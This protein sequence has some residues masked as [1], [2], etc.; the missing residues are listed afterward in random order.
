M[1]NFPSCLAESVIDWENKASTHC[2]QLENILNHKIHDEQ[3]FRIESINCHS[4]RALKD[5]AGCV[6]RVGRRWQT[7]LSPLVSLYLLEKGYA[8]RLSGQ[9]GGRLGAGWAGHLG[10]ALRELMWPRQEC[11][12]DKAG[13]NVQESAVL[14]RPRGAS[15]VLS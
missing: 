14:R 4:P 2:C 10:T 1:S 11:R 8:C 7:L 15:S 13:V 12:A 3:D 9:R 6:S 5:Q